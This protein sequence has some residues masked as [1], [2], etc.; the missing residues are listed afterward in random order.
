[1]ALVRETGEKFIESRPSRFLFWLFSW[2][3]IGLSKLVSRSRL[4][5]LYEITARTEL[6]IESRCVFPETDT[7]SSK[8]HK[9]SEGKSWKIYQIT[10]IKKGG[11]MKV[12]A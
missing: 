7:Q 5:I 3:F 11:A 4:Q 1:M 2:I 9:N 8:K 12:L 6:E 10:A